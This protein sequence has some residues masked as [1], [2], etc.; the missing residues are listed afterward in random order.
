MASRIQ[1]PDLGSH[2]GLLYWKHGVLDTGPPGKILANYL[3]KKKKK[4]KN[5]NSIVHWLGFL[6]DIRRTCEC[7]QPSN[8]GPM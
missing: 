7:Y 5:L 8:V 2:P 4:K 3:K 6:S 1:L